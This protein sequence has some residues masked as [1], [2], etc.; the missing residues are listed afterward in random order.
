MKADLFNVDTFVKVNNLKEVTNPILLERDNIPTIDGLLSYEI[1][2]RTNKDRSTTFAYIDLHGHFL[3]PLVYK[4]W[5]RMNRK[6]ETVVSGLETVSINSKGEIVPDPNGW[7]GLEE[8]YNHYDEIKWKKNDSNIQQ[9]RIDFFKALKKDEVFITKCIVSPPFYRDIQLNNADSGKVSFHEKT[10][11]YSKILRL[12][13]ALK[14]DVSGIVMVNHATRNKIQNLLLENYTDNYMKD[15]KGKNGL[16]RKNVMGKSVDYGARLVITSPLFDE[17]DFNDIPVNFYYSGVPL[18]TLC[19]LFF[20]YF[21]K[22][23]K[24][25]FYKE[26][27][28][29]KDKY[30]YRHPNGE[31]EYVKLLNV[32]KYN[33]DYFEKELNSFI[34]SYSSRFRLIPLENDKNYDMKY[35]IAGQY[36]N[37]ANPSGITSGI[38]NRPCT[39]TD[40]LYLAACDICKDKHVFITRY[41]LTSFTGEFC[42]RIHVMSTI[43]TEQVIISGKL[44]KYYPKVDL[45]LSP[46][47]VAVS[48]RDSLSISNLYLSEAGGDYDGDQVSVRG[49]YD[50][51][52]NRKA[53]EL[54]LSKKNLLGISGNLIRTTE[55]EAIQ[56]M[57]AL[58]CNPKDIIRR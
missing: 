19:V 25:Y 41:P 56:T 23:L 37:K 12:V 8:L 46:E 7:T 39:W 30:A 17:D 45:S 20:P 53:E 32:D 5:K 11:T 27:Y 6:I 58:T 31:I 38:F 14:N 10:Q 24:D 3:N 21:I 50:I 28:L 57:Y 51:N 15:I 36:A 48:F 55:K 43:N 52:A 13:N 40:L 34:K 9:E 4:T 54:M 29:V 1:F 2:G 22:W 33:D 44:Y 47:D 49:I 18:A 26:F 42:T 16:F 35:A